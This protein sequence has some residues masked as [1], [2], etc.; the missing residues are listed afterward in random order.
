MGQDAPA[1]VTEKF[2]LG[3]RISGLY[4]TVWGTCTNDRA[5]VVVSIEVRNCTDGCILA[6]G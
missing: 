3:I 4:A 6:A 5:L 2:V 1:M